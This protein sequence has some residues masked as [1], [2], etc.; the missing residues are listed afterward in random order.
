MFW[1]PSK[2]SASAFAAAVK[3]LASI[4]QTASQQTRVELELV[5]AVD[6]SSSVDAAEFDLQVSGLANAFRHPD[7]ISAIHSVGAKGIAVVL[8]QWSGP[9]Q[10]DVAV[11]WIGVF[12][13]ASAAHFADRVETSSRRLLGTTAIDKVL[14]FSRQIMGTNGFA[15]IRLLCQEGHQESLTVRHRVE[16]PKTGRPRPL[17]DG[18]RALDAERE[19]SVH[20]HAHADERVLRAWN[21]PPVEEFRA[22]RRPG[23]PRRPC[24]ERH[25]ADFA[26]RGKRLHVN[27]IRSLHA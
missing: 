6:A 11:P 13:A 2:F 18:Q 3:C 10:Q 7:V 22:V 19:P 1:L 9:G 14:L 4:G 23:G 20:G 26:R 24:L 21:A 12:D 27:V 8:V 25:L 16:V 15:G 17:L 5:L